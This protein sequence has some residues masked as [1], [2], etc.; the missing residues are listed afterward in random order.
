[1]LL[2]CQPTR[3]HDRARMDTRIHEDTANAADA[4]GT[5]LTH[6]LSHG[7]GGSMPSMNMRQMAGSKRVRFEPT[8]PEDEDVHDYA[9]GHP[10]GQVLKKIKLRCASLTITCACLRTQ[11]GPHSDSPIS[12]GPKLPLSWPV[13]VASRARCHEDLG[14]AFLSLHI[15]FSW[16]N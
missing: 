9:D 6:C 13:P 3:V 10:S 11:L 2:V 5:A 8:L 15:L 7:A 1:M 4:H 16:P 14:N 12:A